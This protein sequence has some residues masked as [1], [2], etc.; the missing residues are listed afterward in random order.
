MKVKTFVWVSIPVFLTL[1]F[2]ARPAPA[3]EPVFFPDPNL[4]TVVEEALGITDPTPDDMLNLRKLY[5]GWQ[6]ISD[7]AGL[8]Y[9]VNLQVLDLHCNQL[10]FIPAE[11]GNL[12]QVPQLED[13]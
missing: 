9:A 11:I 8:D 10:N 1:L 3:A 4:K 7:L 13:K 6:G 5:A 2:T 12:T